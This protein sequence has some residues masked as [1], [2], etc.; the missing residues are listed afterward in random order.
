[1]LF[2]IITVLG[3]AATL[4]GLAFHRFWTTR[5]EAKSTIIYANLARMFFAWVALRAV[6]MRRRASPRA[7]WAYL[8]GLPLWRQP[9]LERW[10]FI[11]FYGSFLY[12]AASGFFFA[13]FVPRGL[14]GYPLV[15]HVMAGGLFAVCLTIIV[16]FKGRDFIAVPRPAGLSL[17]LLDPRKMGLTAARVKLWA[18]WLFAAAGCLLVLSALLPMLPLLRTAGQRVMLDL[19]R[20][21]ALVSLAT[22]VVFGGLSLF[23]VPKTADER[24]PPVPS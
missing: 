11:A 17:A 21:S 8:K 18:F 2:T 23:E 9:V 22:A 7:W 10:L 6:Q 1:M 4:L 5:P 15:A 24:Q 19:H 13:V 3:L 14:F 20:A 16:L 12:L